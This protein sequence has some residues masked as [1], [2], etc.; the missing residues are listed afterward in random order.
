[1]RAS[2][3]AFYTVPCIQATTA[4][5]LAW[6]ARHG[7][8]LTGAALDPRATDYRAASYAPPALLMVGNEARGLPEGL[9]AACDSLV[10]MP[11]RGRADSLNVAMAGTLLL[12]EALHWQ[13]AR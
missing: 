12:Y 9:K 1:V 7:A 11:M 10:I 2:M 13:E 4:D 3:G 8:K 5:F 6:K